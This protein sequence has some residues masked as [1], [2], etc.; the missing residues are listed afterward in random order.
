MSDTV[1]GVTPSE[2]ADQFDY[3]MDMASNNL[4]TLSKSKEIDE[5][6]ESFEK[7]PADAP[8]VSNQEIDYH[9]EDPSVNLNESTII[10]SNDTTITTTSPT[11]S[12]RAVKKGCEDTPEYVVPE[13]TVDVAWTVAES[14]FSVGGAMGAF[15]VGWLTKWL[16]RYA[17]LPDPHQTTQLFF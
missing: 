17:E 7:S 11:N 2:D 5:N 3:F 6:E 16:P 13:Q 12:T 15:V 1:P 8:S 14:S 10:E 4:N 9:A